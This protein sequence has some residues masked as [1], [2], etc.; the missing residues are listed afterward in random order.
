M[1]RLRRLGGLL[2]RGLLVVAV[3]WVAVAVW[4]AWQLVGVVRA[5][6]DEWARGFARGALRG[7][8]PERPGPVIE[9][10]A[11]LLEPFIRAAP[12]P[13]DATARV[14]FVPGHYDLATCTSCG[15]RYPLP[16]GEPTGLCAECATWGGP[17]VA[18][19]DYP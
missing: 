17:P 2:A 18:D 8:L 11:D 10:L 4:R 14:P 19:G 12:E 7:P 9:A 15:R 5:L 13:D 3:A 6:G 1:S 16:V